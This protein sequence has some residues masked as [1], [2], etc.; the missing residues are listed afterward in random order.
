MSQPRPTGRDILLKVLLEED[1]TC[2]APAPAGRI[3]ASI[4]PL[5]AP[6]KKPKPRNGTPAPAQPLESATT[7]HPPLRVELLSAVAQPAGPTPRTPATT[8]NAIAAPPLTAASDDHALL[9]PALPS[10]ELEPEPQPEPQLAIE[11]A[12]EATPI[13]DIASL[14][15]TNLSPTLSSIPLDQSPF[16]PSLLHDSLLSDPVIEILPEPVAEPLEFSSEP[17]PPLPPAPI[18][19]IAP[20]QEI[21]PIEDLAPIEDPAPD[22]DFAPQFDTTPEPLSL[23]EE[24]PAIP[25]PQSFSTVPDAGAPEPVAPVRLE[26]SLLNLGSLTLPLSPGLT[27]P[28][29]ATP[30]ASPIPA[31]A[32]TNFSPR[33]CP[34]LSASSTAST[35][36]TGIRLLAIDLDGTLLDDNKRVSLQTADALRCLRTDVRIV[37]ASARPPRSVRGIYSLLELDT[38]SIHYNGA[39]VWHE[40]TGKVFHHTPMPGHLVHRVIEQARTAFPECLVSCEALDRWYTDRFDNHYTTE[41]GRMFKPDVIAP[42]DTFHHHPMTKVLLLGAPEMI[43]QL[44]QLLQKSLVGDAAVVRCDPELIQ[45][46]HPSAGKGPALRRVANHYGIAMNQVLAIGDAAN[47]VDMLQAAGIAV[48]MDNAHPRVK[49]VSHWIAPSNNDHGVHAALQ[50]YGLCG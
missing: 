38:L 5:K 9:P 45:I 8:V 31:I 10:P 48:A 39:L 29:P 15:T 26:D 35:S 20:I 25:L 2:P 4:P 36:S 21:A 41:T 16:E 46:M 14:A 43:T 3:P 37:I 24:P 49:A 27:S 30:P 34:P 1:P 44:T 13:P 42:L 7:P 19:D 47:D 32:T 22:E 33:A 23:A 12:V 6:S 40:P 11:S 50:K 28:T 18:E 17:A